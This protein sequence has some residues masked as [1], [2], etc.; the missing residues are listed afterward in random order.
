MLG[1]HW[2]WALCQGMCGVPLACT[3]FDLQLFFSFN[4]DS[5]ILTDILSQVTSSRK[6]HGLQEEKGF[7]LWL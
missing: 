7:G 4:S 3:Q 2:G 1:C 6:W 5:C